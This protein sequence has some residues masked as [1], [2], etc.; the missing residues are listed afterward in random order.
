MA[1]I[2]PH[3]GDERDAEEQGH[4]SKQPVSHMMHAGELET[5]SY[6]RGSDSEAEL[7]VPPCRF[8]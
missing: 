1:E 8:E 6:E 2:I 3:T 5:E 7:P 4:S